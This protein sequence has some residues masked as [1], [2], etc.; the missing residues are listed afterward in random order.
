MGTSHTGGRCGGPSVHRDIARHRREEAATAPAVDR[1]RLGI[2]AAADRPRCDIAGNDVPNPNSPRT[3]PV[4]LTCVAGRSR[5]H[6]T[7][8]PCRSITNSAGDICPN[9]E[10]PQQEEPGAESNNNWL[11]GKKDNMDLNPFRMYDL[12]T[13]GSGQGSIAR[14]T[15]DGNQP[16]RR[17]IG[18]VYPIEVL[19]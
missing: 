1:H 4:S 19:R 8:A 11:R 17:H 14:K 13:V 12:R 10:L 15:M 3:S 2:V 7:T 18:A 9:S 6:R 16:C 5:L